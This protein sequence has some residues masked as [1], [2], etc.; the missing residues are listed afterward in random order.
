[1]NKLSLT[2]ESILFATADAYTI[3]SLAKLV[4]VSDAE[5]EEA[6]NELALS[7]EQHSIMLVRQGD[8]VTLATRP[9]HSAILETLRKEELQ[10]DLSKASAETLAVIIYKPGATKAE[11]ELIRGVNASYSLRA[12]QIRGLI[13]TKGV[14]RAITYHPT[15]ALLE[16]FGVADK[17]QLPAYA[18]TMEKLATLLVQS[19][20]L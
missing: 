6:L 3:T 17:D 20:E 18:E 11:I 13:E 7:L 14:G 1:M 2:I 15:L 10:K 12:L 16:S 4:E 19:E 5:I 8:S 9:E